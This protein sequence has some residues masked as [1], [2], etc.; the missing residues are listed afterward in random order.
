M[1]NHDTA[2]VKLDAARRM[3]AEAKDVYD[4]MDLRDQ[5]ATVQAWIRRRDLSLDDENRAAEL[6]VRA[7]REIGR[8]LKESVRPGN[9]QLSTE[10]TIGTRLPQG[11]SRNQSSQYQRMAAVS[12]D[13]F[14]RHM[15]E[16]KQAKE[17]ITTKGVVNLATEGP[18]KPHVARA[19]GENEWYTPPEYI[20]AARTLMGGIDYEGEATGAPLQGQAI[21]YVGDAVAGFCEHFHTFGAVLTTVTGDANEQVRPT[22]PR[23]LGALQQPRCL[24][25][26]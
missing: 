11:I 22:H 1:S 25:P 8:R 12:D 9:P 17:R 13:D 21:L 26:R 18:Q 7:E 6:R 3:L 15:A 19:T 5:A 10:L 2:L 14:E 16:A 20:E 4:L 23:I 24:D